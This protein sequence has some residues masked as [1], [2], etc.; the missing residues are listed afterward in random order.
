MKN[1]LLDCH[2][3]NYFKL[4]IFIEKTICTKSILVFCENYQKKQF[5][6]NK[7]YFF[8]QNRYKKS[9]VQIKSVQFIKF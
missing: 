4:Y 1:F 8:M 9:N 7:H 5:A 2:S 6:Q 3:V